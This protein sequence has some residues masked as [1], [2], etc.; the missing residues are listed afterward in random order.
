M[1]EEYKEIKPDEK[2][3]TELMKKPASFLKNRDEQEP[4]VPIKPFCLPNS[5]EQIDEQSCEDRTS[6]FSKLSKPKSSKSNTLQVINE[7]EIESK[8]EVK[9]V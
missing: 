6:M 7:E 9:A 3:V 4:K 2:L 8:K 5:L 1:G